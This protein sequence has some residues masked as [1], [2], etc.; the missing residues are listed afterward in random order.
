MLRDL[1]EQFRDLSLEIGLDVADPLR[2]ATETLGRMQIGVVIELEERF[3][4]DVQP[5]AVIQ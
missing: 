2:D 4:R 3:E 1:G 5:P